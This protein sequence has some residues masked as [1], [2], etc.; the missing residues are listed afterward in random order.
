MDSCSLVDIGLCGHPFT[1]N[2]KRPKNANTKERLDRAITNSRW[3]ESF[4]A[5]IITHLF[6]HASDHA[7]LILQ[8]KTDRGLRGRGANE[9]KFKEAWLL[10][11]DCERMVE[12]AWIGG[13][14]RVDST[15]SIIKEKIAS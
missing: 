7:P 6:S 14:R 11:D 8:T 15:M 5:S 9:F 1:W 4:P 2:N 12:E 13:G 3:R 10:W